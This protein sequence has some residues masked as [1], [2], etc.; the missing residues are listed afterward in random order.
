MLTGAYNQDRKL[1]HSALSFSDFLFC[2][3]PAF[4]LSC[5]LAFLLS[6]FRGIRLQET[7]MRNHIPE[8]SERRGL[9]FHSF[10]RSERLP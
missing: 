2:C 10:A 1:G 7:G 9:R 6:C 4:L 3:F 5:F 8:A